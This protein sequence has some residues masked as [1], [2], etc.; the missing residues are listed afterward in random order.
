MIGNLPRTGFYQYSFIR[1]HVL[2]L[3]HNHHPD[4]AFHN[5]FVVLVG[6]ILWWNIQGFGTQRSGS[7]WQKN[8]AQ[9]I[10]CSTGHEAEQDVADYS[11]Q[12]GL[13]DL[14]GL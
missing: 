11:G 1:D 8:I 10:F 9:F 2:F 12:K 4:G 14:I 3:K 13:P 5:K 7:P 6:R